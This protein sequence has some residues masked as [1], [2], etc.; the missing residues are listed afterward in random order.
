M[1]PKWPGLQLENILGIFVESVRGHL[2]IAPCSLSDWARLLGLIVPLS[3]EVAD[4][5]PK[6]RPHAVSQRLQRSPSTPVPDL[7]GLKKGEKHL[8]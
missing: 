3:N 1:F 2:R 7:P 5:Q 6:A 4:L 8:L